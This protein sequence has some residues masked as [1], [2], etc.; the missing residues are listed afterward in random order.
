MLE[1][2]HDPNIDYFTYLKAHN[3]GEELNNVVFSVLDTRKKGVINTYELTALKIITSK[4][5]TSH[6]LEYLFGLFDYDGDEKLVMFELLNLVNICFNVI[7]KCFKCEWPSKYKIEI[8]YS[9][10]QSILDYDKLRGNELKIGKHM[11]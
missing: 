11:Y 6:K 2:S 1:L 3:Q 8:V 7:S 10:L 4:S 5:K 9:I